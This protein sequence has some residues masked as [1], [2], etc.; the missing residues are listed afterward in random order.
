MWCFVASDCEIRFDYVLQDMFFY[1]LL[2]VLPQTLNNQRQICPSCSNMGTC[3]HNVSWWTGTLTLKTIA[4]AWKPVTFDRAWAKL[5]ALWF[6]VQSHA[7]KVVL[8]SWY[9]KNKHIFPASRWEPYDPEKKW[10]KYTVS[11]FSTNDLDAEM[12]RFEWK[13][14]IFPAA[15]CFCSRTI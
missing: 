14:L 15:T 4:T 10:D 11:I 9:E 7:G 1:T 13:S 5:K 12:V 3:K 6:F 2:S 8:R